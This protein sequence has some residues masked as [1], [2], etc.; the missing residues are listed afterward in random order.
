MFDCDIFLTSML[1]HYSVGIVAANK[2]LSSN[3]IE[4][5]PIEHLPF[6]NGQLTNTGTSITASGTDINGAAYQTQVASSVTVK[7]T[8][9]KLSQGNRITSPDVRRGAYVQLWQFGDADKYYWTILLDDSNIRKL[10]TVTHAYSGTADES[11]NLDATNSYYHEV[12]TH[13]GLITLH[14]SAANNEFTT[15]DIQLNAAEGYFRFQDGV[16]NVIIVDSTQ[17]L[18]SYANSDGSLL[19]VLGTAMQFTAPDSINM[20]TKNF[21]L[22]TQTMAVQASDSVTVNATNLIDMEAA[23]I[24]IN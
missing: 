19:Q 24:D 6:V 5:T 13:Q 16:G 23:T 7:A 12:S 14:T 2:E 18:F 22:Q 17:N 9:L 1:R 4:V 15:Y 10:E 20:K 11:E 8:W 21:E 3:E